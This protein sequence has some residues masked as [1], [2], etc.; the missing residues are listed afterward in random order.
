MCA[1]KLTVPFSH[2]PAHANRY[3]VPVKGYI[4][5]D[6]ENVEFLAEGFQGFAANT[7]DAAAVSLA[8]GL[9][10]SLSLPL[11]LSLSLPL[12]L[13]LP[14]AASEGPISCPLYL[15]HGS[16]LR[17]NLNSVCSCLGRGIST[18]TRSFD[19]VHVTLIPYLFSL[20]AF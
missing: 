20:G 6:N 8:A 13:C 15:Y 19:C 18:Y 1:S 10:L 9:S 3:R 2:S 14:S 5:S 16:S 4:G 17:S 7:S 11:S 12:S